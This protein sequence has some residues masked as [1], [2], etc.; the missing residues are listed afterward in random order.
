M[1]FVVACLKMGHEGSTTDYDRHPERS[2]WAREM[3]LASTGVFR[4]MSASATSSF[5][6]GRVVRAYLTSAFWNVQHRRLF[7]A[8]SRTVYT[9]YATVLAGLHFFSSRFWQA[10]LKPYRSQTFARGLREKR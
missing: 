10:V 4:R 5:W 7:T 6:H 3:I 1:Q 9:F 2:R 8:V